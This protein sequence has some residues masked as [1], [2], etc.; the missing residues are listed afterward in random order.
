M[1]LLRAGQVYQA[2]HGGR[3][4]RVLQVR[5]TRPESAE[6]PHA[7]VREVLANGK[8]AHGRSRSGI[9]RGKPFIVRLVFRAREWVLPDA[10]R[11][12]VDLMT[13]VSPECDIP[14]EK[15]SGN[16]G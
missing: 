4:I 7:I 5:G 2:T 16:A 11:P 3:Y 15:G 1:S 6:A 10:Y 9:L 14:T 13:P 12:V 8:P